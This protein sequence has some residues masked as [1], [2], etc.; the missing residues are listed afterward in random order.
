MSNTDQLQRVKRRRLASITIIA[1]AL[2]LLLDPK[3]AEASSSCTFCSGNVCCVWQTGDGGNPDESDGCD[4]PL[5]CCTNV[6]PSSPT[7]NCNDV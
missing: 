1:G 4:G 6:H 5:I 2:M 3:P 7:T